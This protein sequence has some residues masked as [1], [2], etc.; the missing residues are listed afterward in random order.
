MKGTYVQI[1]SVK[2]VFDFYFN[3]FFNIQPNACF[4]VYIMLKNFT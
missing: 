3:S 4:C 2:R 1:L